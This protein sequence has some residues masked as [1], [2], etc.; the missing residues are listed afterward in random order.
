[1]AFHLASKTQWRSIDHMLNFK[2]VS[3]EM[4][5]ILKILL[6]KCIDSMEN[7]DINYNSRSF[8]SSKRPTLSFTL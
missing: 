7:G 3:S 4:E 2:L 5:L 1:M 6:N 8:S